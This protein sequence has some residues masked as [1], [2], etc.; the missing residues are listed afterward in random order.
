MIDAEFRAA[1]AA[2]RRVL[3]E[4][5]LVDEFVVRQRRGHLVDH[6]R[7]LVDVREIVAVIVHAAEHVFDAALG[8]IV[9]AARPRERRGEHERGKCE[10]RAT[11]ISH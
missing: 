11:S 4:G 3:R 8:R 6:A 10:K 5:R 1:F 9:V 2:E 7:A